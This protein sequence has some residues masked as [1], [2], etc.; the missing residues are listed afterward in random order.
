MVSAIWHSK[1][2]WTQRRNLLILLPT[3]GSRGAFVKA[4]ILSGGSGTRLRPL[5]YSQQKQLIP[6]ANKP[7]LFYAIEDVI[8]AGAKDIG[9]IVG[10]NKEQVA[11]TVTS[12]E[13]DAN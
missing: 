11:D 13:W 6:I 8:E 1:R 7:V 4:L 2:L 5:T 3:S 12:R 10:P 9:I